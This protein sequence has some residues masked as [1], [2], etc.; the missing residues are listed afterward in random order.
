L[1]KGSDP[2][3]MFM[4]D[5]WISLVASAFGLIDVL[6]VPTVLYRQHEANTFGAG[7]F[8]L[9]HVTKRIAQLARGGR[10]NRHLRR[11]FRQASSFSIRYAGALQSDEKLAVRQIAELH[12]L[13]PL[14]L[15]WRLL[16]HRLLRQGFIQNL[17]SLIAV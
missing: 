11:S 4:H 7:R 2:D 14:T 9:K 13:P 15:R 5:W 8:D 3:E 12:G 10:L 6:R 1:V 16:R 17:V